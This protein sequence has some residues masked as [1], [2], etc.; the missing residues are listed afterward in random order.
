MKPYYSIG[1]QW[2]LRIGIFLLLVLLLLDLGSIVVLA[3]MNGYALNQEETEL[4]NFQT[5]T[6]SKC[7]DIL[8]E[9]ERYGSLGNTNEYNRSPD[10][11]GKTHF[12]FIITSPEGELLYT[13]HTGGNSQAIPGDVWLKTEHTMPVYEHTEKN[14]EYQWTD[15]YPFYGNPETNLDS[16]AYTI[17]GY[18]SF[19]SATY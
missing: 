6:E 14:A 2:A 1:K 12:R 16:H 19:S 15:R 7:Y 11:R 17:Q 18:Y 8:N 5:I 3:E 4:Y 10:Y 13:N 9:W